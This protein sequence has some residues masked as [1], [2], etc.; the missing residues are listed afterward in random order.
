MKIL[1][2]GGGTAGHINPALAIATTAMEQNSQNEILFIGRKGNMEES[3]VKKAGF[4]IEFIEV[5]GFKR[6]LT[7][8]NIAVAYKAMTAIFECKKI[9]KRF[10]PD[11]VVCTGGY[12]SGPVMS[13]AHLMK[14]PSIIHE[15]NVYPGVTVKM[16]EKNASCVAVS[17]EKTIDLLKNKEKCALTGNPIRVEVAG[18][19][20]EKARES[21]AIGDTPF[22]LAFGGSLGA[23]RVN[24]AVIGYIKSVIANG[25]KVS[26]L[27]GTGTRNY[28]EVVREFEKAGIDLAK[29]SNIT[30]TDYI[31]NMSEAMAAADVVIS[32]AGAISISEIMALGKASILIP[33]PNVAHNHQETN[34][35]LL[36]KNG[37][38][39]VVC[40]RELTIEGLIKKI[41]EIIYLP[42]RQSMLEERAKGMAKYDAAKQI[43]ELAEKYAIKKRK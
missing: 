29:Y 2:A 26:V 1:L 32:R 23:T 5:E 10:K 42:D 31:Y 8:K 24:E 43:Y 39:V 28:D 40:E 11:V 13:A 9:I 14:I 36:E 33:S 15:Q 7:L 19:D 6:K 41:E 3:L 18:A 17:F 16:C 21:L 30:V 12:I 27:F 20:R 38:A 35:R 25:K 34:A 22:V 4:P 37:A